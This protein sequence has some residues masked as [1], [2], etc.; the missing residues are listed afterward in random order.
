MSSGQSPSDNPP[1]VLTI[2]LDALRANYRLLAKTA[3]GAR[4]AAAVKADGYGM[5][6]IAVSR[7]LAG[8]GCDCFFVENPG[9]GVAL[10]AALPDA[11]I[12]IVKGYYCDGPEVFLHHALRPV[13]VTAGQVAGW[14][15]V[16]AA[17]GPLPSILKVNTGMNRLGLDETDTRA[18]AADDSAMKSLSPDYLMSHLAFSEDPDHPMNNQQRRKFDELRSLF[19]GLPATLAGSGGVMMGSEYHYDM[20][21][22]GVGLYGGNPFSGRPN[23]FAEV[24]HLEGKILQLREIDSGD[25]VGYGATH[26]ASGPAR[27]AIVGVGYSDGYGRGFD[28]RGTGIL[29][30]IKVPVVGRVSMGSVAVDVSECPTGS[31][32][33]GDYLTLLGHGISLDA[34]SGASGRSPYE[35]LTSLSQC[36]GRRYVGQAEGV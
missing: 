9:E 7:A 31:I 29:N 24:A 25:S 27:I 30:G 35:L 2:D 18:L 22:P 15:E 8:A 16:I 17:Q 13:L 32:A 3:S 11:T 19:P 21:R 33:V 20:V 23:P 1:A 6:M 36:T 34:A 10:R 4:C 5:G 28:N 26:R 14:L 12:Y